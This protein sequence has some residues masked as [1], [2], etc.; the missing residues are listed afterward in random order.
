M[1]IP[2]DF[3]SSRYT[4][5]VMAADMI[6]LR[7]KYLYVVHNRYSTETNNVWFRLPRRLSVVP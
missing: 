5:R 6:F 7:V 3:S 4:E 2:H 1:A